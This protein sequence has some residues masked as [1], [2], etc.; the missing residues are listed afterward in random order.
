[1]PILFQIRAGKWSQELREDV[2]SFGSYSDVTDLGGPVES[3]FQFLSIDTLPSSKT[4]RANNAHEIEV[5]VACIKNSIVDYY[6]LKGLEAAT[7]TFT[8]F[9]FDV[10][11]KT[12]AL[13]L[14][15]NIILDE[16]PASLNLAV[17]CPVRILRSVDAFS[18]RGEESISKRQPKMSF[19]V[20]QS[21]IYNEEDPRLS[22]AR[23][24]FHSRKGEYWW[25]DVAYVS[26]EID[27]SI[28]SLYSQRFFMPLSLAYAVTL[29][30]LQGLEFY[31][32]IIDL[33]QV[34][35]WIRHA[36]YTAIT[37]VRSSKGIKCLN[38][39]SADSDFNNTHPEI[40]ALFQ[41]F[42]SI[43]ERQQDSDSIRKDA[44]FT[45]DIVKIMESFQV[46]I[47]SY[48]I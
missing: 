42:K 38:I 9:A 26:E 13:T 18:L 6:N 33:D 46:C 24:R 31:Y 17:G 4:Q 27:L 10:N 47:I 16:I 5:P 7:S 25:A 45:L 48:L 11:R 44:L 43:S 20:L 22:T 37:R 36:L 34:G 2:L 14:S 23:I 19:G 39:P 28:S 30:S 35:T 29:S 1:M 32:L 21:F 3:P 8:L 41:K 12:G 15:Q 40:N